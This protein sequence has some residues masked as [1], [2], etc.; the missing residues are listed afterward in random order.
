[1]GLFALVAL[2][3]HLCMTELT[4]SVRVAWGVISRGF[5]YGK[6]VFRQIVFKL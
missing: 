2:P 6:Q 4:S 3:E 1:M 5:T